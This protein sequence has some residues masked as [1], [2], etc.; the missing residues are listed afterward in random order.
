MGIKRNNNDGVC[1]LIRADKISVVRFLFSFIIALHST[2]NVC[3]PIEC[4][5]DLT[6]VFDDAMN[7][8]I[9]CTC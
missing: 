2:Y 5:D 9:T 7:D 3:H 1:E 8:E 6:K 4:D